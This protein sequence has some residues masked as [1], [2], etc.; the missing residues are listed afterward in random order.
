MQI[1]PILTLLRIAESGK[2]LVFAEIKCVTFFFNAFN[3]LVLLLVLL[4][5]TDRQTVR[6][7]KMAHRDQEPDKQGA[8]IFAVCLLYFLYFGV[9]NKATGTFPKAQGLY[10]F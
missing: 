3:L 5:W 2:N 8:G 10:M 4:W 7:L 1:K 9:H 6:D